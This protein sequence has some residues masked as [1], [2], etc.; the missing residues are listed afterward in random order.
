MKKLRISGDTSITLI[1]VSPKSKLKTIVN[2]LYT[3]LDQDTFFYSFNINSTYYINKLIAKLSGLD[4]K[5]I[6]KYAYPCTTIGKTMHNKI[7]REKYLQAIERLQQSK[8]LIAHT[9]IFKEDYVD[10]LLDI[11]NEYLV[12]DDFKTLLYYTKYPLEEIIIKT[13]KAK[14]KII[15]FMY[16]DLEYQKIK[17]ALDENKN[18]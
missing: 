8:L 17:E 11:D 7:N 1:G 14:K 15:L 5:L 16:E 13:K 18:N 9:K 4:Y 6:I 10:Y 3:L 12:I 2:I